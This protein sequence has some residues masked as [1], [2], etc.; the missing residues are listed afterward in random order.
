MTTESVVRQASAYTGTPT[1]YTILNQLSTHDLAFENYAGY[2]ESFGTDAGGRTMVPAYYVNAY[3]RGQGDFNAYQAAVGVAEPVSHGTYT[4]WTG[5]NSGTL[6][7]GQ[8]GAVTANVNLYGSE[9]TLVDNALANVAALGQVVNLDRRGANTATYT[10]PWLAFRAQSIGTQAA[11]AAFQAT[12]KW[13][14]GLDTTAADLG[15][16]QAA[17]ALAGG[18]RIYFDAD[19]TSNGGPW[20]AGDGPSAGL[21]ET[22]ATYHE[23]QKKLLFVVDNDPLFQLGGGYLNTSGIV[24]SG[25]AFQI[26]GQT[27]VRQPLPG[28]SIPDGPIKTDG[29]YT[30]TVSLQELA[31]VVKGLI[32]SLHT[33]IGHHGLLAS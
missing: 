3:H 26:N 15:S 5:R 10:A 18:Q 31:R 2:Q 29:W 33:G 11:D 25:V 6:T 24:N 27:V 8:T 14:V 19:P 23:G 22:Y 4:A 1:G 9:F 28:W 21:R 30:E 17:I 32:A 13:K 12:G 16:G 7:S 20:F